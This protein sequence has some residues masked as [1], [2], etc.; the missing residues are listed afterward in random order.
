MTAKRRGA[1]PLGLEADK[2]VVSE[3]AGVN[4]VLG[5]RSLEKPATFREIA[6]ML[7]RQG[8]RTKRGGKWHP[9]TVR[10]IWLRRGLYWGM[11]RGKNG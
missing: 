1:Y 7:N 3:L 4:I 8:Y 6:S 11:I 5:L 2:P 9:S 10:A